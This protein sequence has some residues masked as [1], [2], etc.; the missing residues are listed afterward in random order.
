MKKLNLLFC[1]LIGLSFL[2][3]SYYCNK[4]DFSNDPIIGTWK[5]EKVVYTF[6]D[7]EPFENL[8]LK[9][10]SSTQYKYNEDGTF[11]FQTFLLNDITEECTVPGNDYWIGTWEKGLN[12]TYKRSLAY[13]YNDQ[14][15]SKYNDSTDVFVFSNNNNYLQKIT[16]YEKAGIAFDSESTNVSEIAFFIRIE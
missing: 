11:Y 4:L 13:N 10:S 5:M 12:K 14:T 3:F 7:K 9:C 8:L 6:S 1:I 15:Q 16:N 2:S